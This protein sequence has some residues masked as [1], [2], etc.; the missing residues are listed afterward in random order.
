[1]LRRRHGHPQEPDIVHQGLVLVQGAA[2]QAE[3][4]RD[5]HL[6]PPACARPG[7]AQGHPPRLLTSRGNTRKQYRTAP[8]RM[9]A[10]AS[11]TPRHSP[12]GSGRE[13]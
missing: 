11:S 9:P 12:L 1:M 6:A 3:P 13:P 4:R 7:R 8:A 10:M 2:L 5:D